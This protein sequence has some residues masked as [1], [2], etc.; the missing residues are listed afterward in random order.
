MIKSYLKGQQHNWDQHVG[1]LAAA[2]WATPYESTGMTPNLLMFGREFRMCIEVMLGVSK[3]L[4]QEEIT[5]YGD[6]VDTMRE[7]M[8]QTH[9][10]AQKYLGKNAIQ[11]KEHYDAKC[12]LNKYKCGDLV[13]YATD[14][15]QLYLALNLWILFEGHVLYLLSK[16]EDGRLLQC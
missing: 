3:N 11:T 5:S 6:Y 4:N 14:I 16:G 12:T 7:Q 13:W 10:I 15:K 2:H 1:C 8:Q 9:D